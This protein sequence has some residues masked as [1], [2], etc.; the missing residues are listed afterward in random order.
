MNQIRGAK[1]METYDNK[2]DQV[3]EKINHDGIG[4]IVA[5]AVDNFS[6]GFDSIVFFDPET[7]EYK[8]RCWTKN[9]IHAGCHQLIEV[10]RI[11]GNWLSDNEFH[12]SDILDPDEITKLRSIMPDADVVCQGHLGII[13][14]DLSERLYDYLMFHEPEDEIL[15]N[16]RIAEG[17]H[18]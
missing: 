16:I 1:K 4:D 6:P 14:V 2:Y 17:L 10:Y 18:S 12:D 5:T 15:R 11:D 9:T 13:G 3:R 7:D 8:S